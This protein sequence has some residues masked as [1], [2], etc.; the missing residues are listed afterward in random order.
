MTADT[1]DGTRRIA[2]V[3]WSLAVIESTARVFG[4]LSPGSSCRS[5][6]ALMLGNPKG[7]IV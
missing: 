1:C 6:G 2:R 4:A 7:S 5:W 3:D